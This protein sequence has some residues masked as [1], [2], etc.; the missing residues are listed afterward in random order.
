[1][2]ATIA[3]GWKS[4]ISKLHSPLPLSQR[5]SAKLLAVLD[6]S[7]KRELARQHPAGLPGSKQS[8]DMFLRSILENPLFIHWNGS[9]G[10]HKTG[11]RLD[12][13]RDLM[14]RPMDIFAE[15]VAVGSATLST[16]NTCLVTHLNSCLASPDAKSSAVMARSGA[17]A[18]VVNWL[19]SS[20]LAESGKF[21][22]NRDFIQTIIRTLVADS[23]HGQLLEWLHRLYSNARQGMSS[24]SHEDYYFFLRQYITAERGWGE[25]LESAISLFLKIA[26]DPQQE[27][28]KHPKL[29][30]YLQNEAR[31]LTGL[32]L[33]TPNEVKP[34][35]AVIEPLVQW[36][37]NSGDPLSSRSVAFYEVYLAASPS[38]TTA[39][40]YFQNLSAHDLTV[41]KPTT[42]SRTVLLG[43]RTAELC[44]NEGRQIETTAVINFLQE[45][46]SKEIGLHTQAHHGSPKV[47]SVEAEERSL[48]LLENLAMV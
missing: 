28:S 10:Q 4:L 43:L 25:G 8:T 16:A 40:K 36:I 26:T 37:K 32:L 13:V 34:Q 33:Q 39:L 24:S 15:Q 12:Q 47:A 9:S 35:S 11:T 7:F 5:D 48:H 29:R 21:L 46:F 38:P 42:R 20:G 31:R 1:M 27:N 44:L 6:A 19:W 22:Q 18:S 14:K 2:K 45:N 30:W 3:L 17:G 23:N 41:Q